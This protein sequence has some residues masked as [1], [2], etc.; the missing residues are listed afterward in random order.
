MPFVLFNKLLLINCVWNRRLGFA[1]LAFMRIIAF[2][3]HL[4]ATENG[5]TRVNFKRIF[6][7]TCFKFA[8]FY[9]FL[10]PLIHMVMQEMWSVTGAFIS[11]SR[12]SE[13]CFDLGFN[14][15]NLLHLFLIFGTL[16]IHWGTC[17]N[18]V[19]LSNI[20]RTLAQKEKNKYH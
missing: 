8:F 19:S 4:R 9:F 5:K 11:A 6:A 10:Q 3:I 18:I 13:R 1:L 15:H 14:S 20:F 17:L 2:F 16:H 12:I 7:F